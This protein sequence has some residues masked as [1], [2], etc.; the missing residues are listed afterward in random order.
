MQDREWHTVEAVLAAYVGSPEDIA[1]VEPAVSRLQEAV[2]NGKVSLLHPENCRPPFST[3]TDSLVWPVS[4]S[5]H[6]DIR[7]RSDDVQAFVERLREEAFEAAFIFTAAGVS[8]YTAGYTCYLADIP[9]RI[10]ISEEFGGAVLSHCIEPP[11]GK[12]E[13]E[14]RQLYMLETVGLATPAR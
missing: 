5:E 11:S 10:G 6:S 9:I 1:A 7:W 2:S 8:P 14:K 3:G 13:L 4:R 12:M